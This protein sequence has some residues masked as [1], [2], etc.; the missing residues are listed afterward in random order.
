LV[1][2]PP[3][4]PVHHLFTAGNRIAIGIFNLQY[5]H[6]GITGSRS[7]LEGRACCC[8]IAVIVFAKMADGQIPSPGL[9][10]QTERQSQG[11]ADVFKAGVHKI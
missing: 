4:L 3:G 11:K 6:P 7:E 5:P 1:T 9:H 8:P 10:D 2:L